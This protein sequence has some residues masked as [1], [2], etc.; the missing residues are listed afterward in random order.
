MYPL[1]AGRVEAEAVGRELRGRWIED[2]RTGMFVFVQSR[3]GMSFAGRFDSG[4]WWTGARGGPEVARTGAL[5]QSRPMATMRGFLTAANAA[6]D[7]NLDALATAVVLI[8]PQDD[9]GAD[10]DRFEI[11]RA[12]Y[13]VI[14]QTTFRLWDL[15]HD[16]DGEGDD[17]SVVLKQAGTGRD[18][19]VSISFWREAGRWYLSPPPI[20][21]LL[22]TRDRLEAARALANEDVPEST[23]PQRPREAMRSFLLSFR[24]SSDGSDPAALAALDLRGRQEITRAHDGQLLAGYLKRVIDRAGYVIWQEIPDDPTSR[25]PY[26]HF[27]H[28]EGDVVIALV[29]TEEGVN[30]QFT[31][32]T[33]RT[34]RSVYAS[35]EDMP[36]APGVTALEDRDIHFVIRNGL[37]GLAPATLMPLGPL[38]RWQWG[39]L[40]ATVLLA[41]GAGHLAQRGIGAWLRRSR[42]SGA[43]RGAIGAGAQ[44]WAVRGLAAG[45]VL[46]AAGWILGL[47]EKFTQ[48][49]ATVAVVLI[50]VGLFLIGWQAIGAVAEGYRKAER[51]TGHNLILLS[52]LSGVLRGLILLT[53]VLAI[54]HMLSLPLTSVLAGFGIGGIAFALAVQ[55]T[56]QNL[57]SGFNLFADRPIS[58]GDFCRFG[59]KMG[60]VEHIGLRSTRLRTL[61]RTVISV[62][63]SQFLDMEL[64]NFSRR[65]RFPFT[66]TLQLRYK[67]T[68]DQMRYVPV[69]LPS[70][71]SRIRRSS[72]GR[73]GC[74]TWGSALTLWMS[75]FFSTS[76]PQISTRSQPFE[77]TCALP[78]ENWTV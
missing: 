71:S 75:R 10:V 60:M 58:V 66:T 12:L 37:R 16:G 36:V 45:L 32:E 68:P 38:E 54:A 26:V 27:Q 41:L 31:P 22:A 44:A 3:E 29:E 42:K 61:D 15:P 70:S 46:L 13:S 64:E 17:A 69:E 51:I 67:T 49:L 8:R 73:S 25:V 43:E 28:P 20:D 72:R 2:G 30:W 74:G 48:L 1:Y 11:A 39:A 57:L 14:D 21:R 63:N 18:V 35:M 34:I 50:V 59:E 23:G 76:L 56:L 24:Y 4:E 52:L 62:P 5:N 78:P 19:S 65:D 9:P 7:G 40:V 55:P 77:K 33:L 53:A 6:L 47:P